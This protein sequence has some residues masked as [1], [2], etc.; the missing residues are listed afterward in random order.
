MKHFNRAIL[1]LFKPGLFKPVLSSTIVFPIAMLPV[2]M[3][4]SMLLLSACSS[5]PTP[6]VDTGSQTSQVFSPTITLDNDNDQRIMDKLLV[7]LVEIPAGRF[8][9][10]DNQGIGEDDELPVHEVV[11]KRFAIG[12]FEVTFEQ[13]DVYARITGK[14][15][16]R[17]RWGRGR[18]PVVNVNWHDVMGFIEWA[19]EVTG[20]RLRL[21][22]EAEWEY[23]ARAGSEERY[24]FGNNE[25][26]L[27]V[28]A[29]LAD[30]AT[31]M[32]WRNKH[33]NDGFKTT[34]PVGSFKP[35]AFGLYDMHGNVWEWLGDCWFLDY[36]LAPNDTRRWIKTDGC[37]MRAQRG[38]SW[39]FGAE[40]ARA[41]YRGRGNELDK[42]VTL[43]FRLAR[44]L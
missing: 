41:S 11:V 33:C 3:Y 12:R 28:H 20:T 10:G 27:C 34:A 17:A 2:A 26:L 25:A 6:S 8:Y 43:G 16:P 5:Q 1:R 9:M 14:A 19:S 31:N 4:A 29:N 37:S 13:Y 39:F 35:N 30:N 18:Q 42:S 24:S 21:P 38:G 15:L 40:E 7:D 22:T 23:A 44:D 32:R 36:K